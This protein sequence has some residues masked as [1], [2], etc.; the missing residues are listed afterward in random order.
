MPRTDRRTVKLQDFS[1]LPLHTLSRDHK[2]KHKA[3]FPKLGVPFGV[4]IIRILGSHMFMESTIS[5]SAS[6]DGPR[7]LAPRHRV[8]RPAPR[9]LIGVWGFRVSR[10]LSG[11]LVKNLKKVM[12]PWH[13]LYTHIMNTD[14][15]FTQFQGL[16]V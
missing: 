6:V 3:S 1:Q 8:Q 13:V 10:F 15:K 11:L 12:K 5:S 16:K 2:K 14:F 9:T 7:R 4:P